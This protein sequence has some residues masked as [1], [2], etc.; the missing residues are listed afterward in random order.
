[1]ATEVLL[2][3]SP[4]EA[5][6]AFGDGSGVTVLGGGTIVMPE[7][8]YGRLRPAKVVALGQAGM[9]GVSRADGVV[10]IGAATPIAALEDGDEPL[11]S[12]ARHV[13]DP[14]IR[15]QATVGGNLC[16]PPAVDV[17]RGDLQAALV[18]LAA[19]VR[20]AGP[21]GERVESVEEFLAK[22]RSDRLVLE[23]EYDDRDHRSGHAAVTRPH[24]HHYTIL[25]ACCARAGS[26]TRVAIAGAG[27]HALRAASVEKA[28]AEGEPASIAAHKALD[29]VE[30]TL[31]DDALASAWYRRRVLPTV[32]ARALASLEKET[33]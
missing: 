16:A 15:A 19:R 3:T 7:I 32:V 18:A 20:S 25:C 1:M 4:A 6:A 22:E 30:D 12:V 5:V 24:G 29:D 27:P 33:A 14:E 26:E 23:V 21:G 8:V 31:R 28:L 17:P 2:P 11:A 9:A 10:H 13:A